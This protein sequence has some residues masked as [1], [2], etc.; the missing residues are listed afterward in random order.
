MEAQNVF[1]MGKEV[2]KAVGSLTQ[3]ASGG[4]GDTVPVNSLKA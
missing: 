2:S 4:E 3:A 1:E